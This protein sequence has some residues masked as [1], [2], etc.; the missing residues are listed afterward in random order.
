[1]IEITIVSQLTMAITTRVA[2]RAPQRRCANPAPMLLKREDTQLLGTKVKILCKIPWPESAYHVT[3][4]A[5]Q[6]APAGTPL[7]SAR[8]KRRHP[9]CSAPFWSHRADPIHIHQRALRAKPPTLIVLGGYISVCPGGKA[10]AR[11]HTRARQRAVESGTAGTPL[12]AKAVETS[13]ATA[14]GFSCAP[15]VGCRLALFSPSFVQGPGET[16]AQVTRSPPELF[17]SLL[18]SSS[19]ASHFHSRP[20]SHPPESGDGIKHG[21]Q[22][23]AAGRCCSYDLRAPTRRLPLPI[24]K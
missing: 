22:K 12:R 13:E 5:N 6:T 16:T 4:A 3:A 14:T 15:A 17:P 8:R 10:G 24:G 1:M 21:G 20:S 11:K 23:V 18:S 9:H 7:N 2:G 19:S